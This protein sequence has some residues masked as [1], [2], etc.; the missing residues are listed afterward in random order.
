M[1][2]RT[3]DEAVAALAGLSLVAEVI[4]GGD[5]YIL[6]GTARDDGGPVPVYHGTFQIRRTGSGWQVT[7]TGPGQLDAERRAPS[8]AAAVDAVHEIITARGR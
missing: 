3:L 6:G 8:L 1:T 5:G 7:V 2:V 4:G